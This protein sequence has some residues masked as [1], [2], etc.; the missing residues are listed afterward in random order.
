MAKFPTPADR[1]WHAYQCL[2]RDSDG[3]LPSYRDLEAKYGLPNGMLGKTIKQ[4]K[5]SHEWETMERIARALETSAKWIKEEVGDAPIPPP[6]VVIPPRPGMPWRRH[7]EI[8]GWDAS[9]KVLLAEG[10]KVPPEAFLAAADMPVYRPVDRI[11]PEIAL[12]AA[13]YCWSTRTRAEQIH[14]TSLYHRP[15]RAAALKKRSR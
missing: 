14:Y 1:V 4:K 11:D 9:V 3:E 13:M 2:P 5:H 8:D 7:C 6:G 12:G 15:A 10:S